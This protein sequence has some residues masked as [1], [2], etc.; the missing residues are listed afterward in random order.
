MKK[1]IAGKLPVVDDTEQVSGKRKLLN[2][3]RK[4]NPPELKFPKEQKV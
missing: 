4:Q 1:K 2:V 3:K